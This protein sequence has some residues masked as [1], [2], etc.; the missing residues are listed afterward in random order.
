MGWEE[1]PLCFAVRRD[2]D[3]AHFV[4]EATVGLLAWKPQLG[5]RRCRLSI[6]GISRPVAGDRLVRLFGE[7]V[8]HRADAIEHCVDFGELD[9]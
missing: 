8:E 5:A 2:F 9:G 4:G 1:Q 6:P 7:A 3:G